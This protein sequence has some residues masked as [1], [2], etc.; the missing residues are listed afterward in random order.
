M[1]KA[2]VIS[3]ASVVFVMCVHALFTPFYETGVPKITS[4]L[5]FVCFAIP[6]VGVLLRRSWG[7]QPALITSAV[8]PLIHVLF[9]PTVGFYGTHLL[10]AKVLV[11]LGIGACLINL[12][13]MWQHMRRVKQRKEA[14]IVS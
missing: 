2:L 13:L 7:W 8:Y 14:E 4:P 3:L 12:V 9:F 6:F 10:F 1:R 11:A 5:L